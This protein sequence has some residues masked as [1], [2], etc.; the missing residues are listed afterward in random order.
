[1]LP[2]MRNGDFDG[3]RFYGQLF[4]QELLAYYTIWLCEF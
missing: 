3:S 2:I 1:V 4:R